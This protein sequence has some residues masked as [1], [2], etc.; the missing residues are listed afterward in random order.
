MPLI[1]VIGL[2]IAQ[3][4]KISAKFRPIGLGA[5]LRNTVTHP[6]TWG[7]DPFLYRP[8][9]WFR[10]YRIRST[11]RYAYTCTFNF[12]QLEIVLQKTL[13]DNLTCFSFAIFIFF[14]F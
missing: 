7:P 13:T 8:I 12:E 11:V 5:F 2:V 10:A 6:S 1:A 14:S 3:K 9:A 4:I